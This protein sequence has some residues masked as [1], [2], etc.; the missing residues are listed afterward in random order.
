M[1]FDGVESK[2]L[3]AGTW[4][5]SF[6]DQRINKSE[7]YAIAL[8]WAVQTVTTVGYGDIGSKNSTER[9]VS[10]ICMVMG[11]FSF[12]YATGTLSSIMQTLDHENA[13]L[14]DQTNVLDKIYK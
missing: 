12:T 3:F 7:I 10:A 14:I 4:L 9:W 6:S 13:K 2:K 8:T 1:D 11:V 5:E